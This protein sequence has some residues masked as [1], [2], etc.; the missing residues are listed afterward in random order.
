VSNRLKLVT[1][2][3]YNA[4]DDLERKEAEIDKDGVALVFD[5]EDQVYEDFEIR[6][7]FD[8]EMEQVDGENH[9]NIVEWVSKSDSGH[10]FKPGND[11]DPI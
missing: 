9:W 1:L 11:A 5:E 2:S 3:G 10:L 7:E 4:E 8:E 6:E